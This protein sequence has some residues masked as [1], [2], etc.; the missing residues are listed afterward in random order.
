MDDNMKKWI[1]RIALIVID[2][3]LVVAIAY[4]RFL[5][6]P[7]EITMILFQALADGFF[8]IGFFNLG[9]GA[10]V[11]ISS[12]GFFDIFGF[13]FKSFINFFV[14]R[15]MVEQKGTYYEYKVKKA[16]KRKETVMF[17]G[18]LF[19]GVAMMAIGILFNLLV[20]A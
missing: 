19:V 10:L 15:S 9:F 6:P 20:Y 13:A 17:R 2:L 12:T 11:M 16:E 8:V 1:K 4:S 5:N 14:P 18:M 3:A 7:G